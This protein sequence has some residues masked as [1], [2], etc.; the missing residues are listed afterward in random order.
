MQDNVGD[1]RRTTLR[2]FC[3]P[4][5]RDSMLYPFIAQLERWAGFTRDDRPAARLDKLKTSLGSVRAALPDTLPLLADLLGI[6]DESVPP[7]T[8]DPPR[9]REMMISL[10][11]E[12]YDELTKDR[13]LL[14]GTHNP[15]H[16]FHKHAVVATGRTARALVTNDVG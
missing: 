10:W 13:P 15:K 3:S 11:F 2:Y 4:H 8:V 14:A 7:V 12:L 9:K 16:R 5:H 1:D 6:A